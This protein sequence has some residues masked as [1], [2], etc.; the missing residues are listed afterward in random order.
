MPYSRRDDAAL[1]Q[2]SPRSRQRAVGLPAARRRL[3]L[4]ERGADRRRRSVAAGRHAVRPEAH[5]RD[6]R[7]HAPRHPGGAVDR[8]AG[9]HPRQRRSLLRQPVGRGRAHRHLERERAGDGRGGAGAASR[10]SCGRRPSSAR[11]A[12]TCGASSAHSSSRASRS[13]CPP[14]PSTARP[15]SRSAARKCGS[16]RWG[17]RTRRATCWCTCPAIAPSSPATSCSSKA[18]R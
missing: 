12:T 18:T 3:G 5:A 16:T 11:R 4:V 9:Q 6:A 17:R 7:R 14:R 10:S 8:D 2:G 13:R 1:H 15:R